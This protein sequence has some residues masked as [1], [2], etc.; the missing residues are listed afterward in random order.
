MNKLKQTIMT[1]S[2]QKRK[3]KKLWIRA[4]TTNEKTQEQVALELNKMF[5]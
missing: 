1:L 2:G 5:R 3:F 4:V